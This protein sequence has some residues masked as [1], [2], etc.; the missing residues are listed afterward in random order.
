VVRQG[1]VET[2]ADGRWVRSGAS[3]KPALVALHTWRG[4]TEHYDA[5]AAELRDY[6]IVSILPP[7]PEPGP[8]PRRVEQWV[9]YHEAV[10][11][12]VP[13]EPPY[14]FLGWSFGGVVAVELA[15]RFEVA[16]RGRSFVGLIDT[17]RPRLVPLSTSDFVWFHLAAAAG[18]A[19]NRARL[20]Y[21]RQ[22]G[23]FLF[24]RRYPTIGGG[25]RSLL[26]RLGYRRDREAKHSVKPTDPLIASVHVAYLNYRGDAVPF[27]VSLYATSGSSTKAREP[28]LR[29]A[30]WL[31]AGFDL[32]EVPGSHFT[33]FEPEYVGGLAA[34]IRASLA[35]HAVEH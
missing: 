24:V 22:K 33:L 10:L 6:Q 20:A 17:I 30:P 28:V 4:E 26:L 25:A 35:R 34:A 12:S 15:R 29:W 18:M 1:V 31:H 21:L 7:S 2:R 3:D 13:L 23:L 14:R 19:D 11:E 27:P 8:M 9:D 32:T 16:G 5:L